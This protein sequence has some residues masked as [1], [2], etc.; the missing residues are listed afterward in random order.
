MS[1]RVEDLCLKAGGF[2]LDHLAFAIPSGHYAVL[3]GRTGCGKTTMLE[4]ICGLRHVTRGRI[5]V[6]DT[7]ITRL[8]PSR[9]G[10]GLV[11][12][13][14]A[15]FDP[16]NVREHLAFA[17]RIRKW[18]PSNIHARVHELAGQLGLGA[19][20]ER[21]PRALSGGERQRVALGRALS[22]RPAVLCLDEPFSALDEETHA[23]MCQLLGDIKQRHEVTVLHITHRQKEARLLADTVLQLEAGRLDAGA[24]TP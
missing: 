21:L 10:I 3:M 6:G 20:L 23:D 11:P 16:M 4:A 2:R 8:H 18:S 5:L 22:F 13:D 17:L 15:L 14:L 7:D 12:Q 24:P 9:R 19:L 1:I